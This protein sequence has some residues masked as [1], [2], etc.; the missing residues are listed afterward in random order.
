MRLML[1]RHGEAG[2]ASMDSQRPL[3]AHGRKQVMAMAHEHA[4][5]LSA[6]TVILA[7]PYVRAQQ[8]AE[9]VSTAIAAFQ[10]AGENPHGNP[11]SRAIKALDCI[12]PESDP[13]DVC[14]WLAGYGEQAC[15]LLIGHNPLFTDLL[16]ALVGYPPGREHMD[17]GSLAIIDLDVVALGCGE[18]VGLYHSAV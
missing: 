12:R 11:Q 9:L 4:P 6:S 2:R 8:T 10:N 14:R 7:S 16:N 13:L 5:A 1:L 17:T 3:T 15:V 18:L